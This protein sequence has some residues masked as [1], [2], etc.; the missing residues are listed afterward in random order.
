VI[1]QWI[2]PYVVIPM[3]YNTFPVIEQDPEEFAGKVES[4]NKETKVVILEPGQIYK[5]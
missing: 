3:H 5:E 4:I 2:N 1:A